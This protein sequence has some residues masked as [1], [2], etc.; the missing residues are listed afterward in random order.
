MKRARGE[1]RKESEKGREKEIGREKATMMAGY[2]SRI[3][4]N[5]LISLE[6]ESFLFPTYLFLLFR[7]LLSSY[8]KKEEG[9]RKKARKNVE[10]WRRK[11][12]KGCR[13]GMLRREGIEK[14]M[15]GRVIKKERNE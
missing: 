1:R 9:E 8:Q 6:T 3:R 10:G 12:V 2:K 13:R 7:L 15:Q 4:G 14:K 5:W 11:N